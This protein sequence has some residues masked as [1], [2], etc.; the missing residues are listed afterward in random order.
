MPLN[1]SCSIKAFEANVKRSIDEGK[2]QGQA[3]A[4]AYSVL[5][6]ACGIAA[7]AP[8]M[9]PKEIVAKGGGKEEAA[10]DRVKGNKMLLECC[11]RMVDDTWRK[12]ENRSLNDAAGEIVRDVLENGKSEGWKGNPDGKSKDL[13]ATAL[14]KFNIVPAAEVEGTWVLKS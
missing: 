2:E 1:E 14:V 7:D 5:R 8:K 3:V 13:I 4:I 10:P 9:T 6:K 12:Y 11:G